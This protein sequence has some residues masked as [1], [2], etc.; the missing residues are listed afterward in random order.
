MSDKRIEELV[1]EEDNFLTK[2]IKLHAIKLTNY[3]FFY[4]YDELGNN[5]EFGDKNILIYGENGTGKSSLFK[6][7]EILTKEK[8]DTSNLEQNIFDK[9]TPSK[10]EYTFSE[11]VLV[12]GKFEDSFI[13]LE[14]SPDTDFNSLN[15]DSSINFLRPLYIFKPMLDYKKLL[16]LHYSPSEASVINIYEMLKELLKDY[17]L[18]EPLGGSK[19]PMGILEP[20]SRHRF[21]SSDKKNKRETP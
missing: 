2:N 4:Q 7:L 1:P 8:F 19:L 3:R 9:N 18:V 15:I 17:P 21:L 13:P 14:I 6:A 12:K 10:I 11:K 20:F 5:F 16:K